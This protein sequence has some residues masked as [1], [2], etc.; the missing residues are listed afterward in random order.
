MNLYWREI[1]EKRNQKTEAH[2]YDKFGNIRLKITNK[3][4][5]ELIEKEKK[6]IDELCSFKG[7]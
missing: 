6:A 7:F 2:P 1:N 3:E 5:A 4:F